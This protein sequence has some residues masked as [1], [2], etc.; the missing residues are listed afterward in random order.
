MSMHGIRRGLV[1]VPLVAAVCRPVPS[2]AGEPDVPP[3]D[4][5]FVAADV[6]A[7]GNPIGV[8]IHIRGRI[9]HP[10]PGTTYE[11]CYQIRLHSRAGDSG[12]LLGDKE[13]PEG[14]AFPISQVT[15][16]VGPI[17]FDEELDITRSQISG[18]TRLPARPEGGSDL[19]VVLRIEPQLYDANERKYLT[20]PR[21]SAAVLVADVGKKSKVYR[22]QSLSSWMVM[23]SHGG[24][25][26]RKTLEVF[27]TVDVYDFLD[28]RI[29]EAF[30]A[31]LDAA[32]ATPQTKAMFIEALPA[33]IL[34]INVAYNLLQ[35]LKALAA[36][37]DAD[38]KAAAVKKLGED[39]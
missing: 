13:M 2:L 8:G 29:P 7:D 20:K 3:A 12:P 25:D 15:G 21:T 16:G 28:N 11:L 35:K 1:L 33:K 30:E 37:E 23:K 14:K 5:V 26:A 4:E 10:K 27:K 9:A 36:G 6:A 17:E 22:L 32:G 31:V 34:K 38:L 24:W 18:M 39:S 19:D